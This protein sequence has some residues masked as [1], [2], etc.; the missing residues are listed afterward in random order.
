[1][2]YKR[3]GPHDST[4]KLNPDH[5]ATSQQSPAADTRQTTHFLYSPKP[6]NYPIFHPKLPSRCLV[7]PPSALAASTMP[8][9]VPWV[10][11]R[12]RSR[13]RLLSS[14]V[15]VS[16]LSLTLSFCYTSLPVPLHTLSRVP[17]NGVVDTVWPRLP[18][19]GTIHP[20]RTSVV[21]GGTSNGRPSRLAKFG[22]MQG[23][24]WL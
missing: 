4:E 6:I 13:A 15:P 23:T 20:H 14:R 8:F 21:T 12:L 18:F 19:L 11:P 3:S 9:P 7:S 24:T 5:P 16:R 2:L 10:W 1:M 17:S 22:W